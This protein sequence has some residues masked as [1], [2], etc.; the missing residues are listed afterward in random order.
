MTSSRHKARA[1]VIAWARQRTGNSKTL[2]LDTETTGLGPHAEI[3]D[4][5]VLDLDGNALIDTLIAPSICIPA[6]SSRIH[7]IVDADVQNAPAWSDIY[8]ELAGLIRERPVVVYNASF[9]Q[10]MI[11]ACCRVYACEPVSVEWHCAMQ[12]YARYAGERSSHKRN[13]FRLHKLG[14]AVSAFGLPA[15]THRAHSDAMA[16]RNL[17]LALADLD[18]ESA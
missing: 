4:L 8:P 9:D 14:D 2:F 17:V 15:G 12:Q 10:R 11:A 18:P 7:G 13:R 6:E 1:H 16:C 5:A 3:I